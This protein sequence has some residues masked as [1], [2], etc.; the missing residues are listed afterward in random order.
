MASELD[1]WHEEELLDGE[2]Y[3]LPEESARGEDDFLLLMA[4]VLLER[5][6]DTLTP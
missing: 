2:R 5:L 4:S 3:P 6:H 1:V